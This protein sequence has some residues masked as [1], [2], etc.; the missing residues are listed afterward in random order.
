MNG[1]N[2]DVYNF[3]FSAEVNGK[4]KSCV[5]GGILSKSLSFSFIMRLIDFNK[6]HAFPF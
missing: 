5:Q 4:Q 1:K 3:T 6:N 2:F